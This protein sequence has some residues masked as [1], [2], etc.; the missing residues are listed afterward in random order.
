[1]SKWR[2]EIEKP[3]RNLGLR[4]I[5]KW[6]S[7]KF[8]FFFKSGFIDL[9]I[10]SSLHWE[11]A[12]YFLHKCVRS[13]WNLE[14]FVALT[15]AHTGMK[16]FFPIFRL[17][18]IERWLDSFSIQTMESD[19]RALKLCISDMQ[20]KLSRQVALNESFRSE[21]RQ[22]KTHMSKQAADCKKVEDKLSDLIAPNYGSWGWPETARTLHIPSI[23]LRNL[24]LRK[25][26]EDDV[27]HPLSWKTFNLVLIQSV[28][29]FWR[30]FLLYRPHTYNKISADESHVSF[31]ATRRSLT[32]G[33]VS[34]GRTSWAV[35]SRENHPQGQYSVYWYYW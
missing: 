28:L 18:L 13:C 35:V 25:F 6:L 24:C 34:F 16:P 8:G 15:D 27:T 5:W 20:E 22:I 23:P 2:L 21:L 31:V 33:V 26:T 3:W 17:L 4:S 32:K 29:R 12:W 19:N 9:G 10:S 30:A 11:W 7:N 14:Y 1:M